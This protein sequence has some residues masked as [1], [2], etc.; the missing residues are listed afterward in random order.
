MRASRRQITLM[1]L[2]IF[3]EADQ[4]LIIPLRRQIW[5]ICAGMGIA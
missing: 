1:L 4:L 3:A 5:Q 2:P